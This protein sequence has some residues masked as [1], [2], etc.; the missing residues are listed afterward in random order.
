MHT[1]RFAA[2]QGRPIFCLDPEELRVHSTAAY[3]E[4]I[5]KVVREGAGVYQ[6]GEIEAM[7][8]R[9]ERR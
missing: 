2:A 9:V 7:M 3:H 1:L 5:A 4:G 8:G 6:V